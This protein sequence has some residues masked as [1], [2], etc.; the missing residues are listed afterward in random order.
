MTK[1][2]LVGVWREV[3][4]ELVGPDGSVKRDIPRASQ[5][6]YTA[7][8][9]MSVVNA[10][11]GRAAVTEADSRMDLNAAG[12]EARAQAALGVVAYAG[13]FEVEGD[14][15]LHR[16]FTSLNPNRVGET[17]QR[18]ATLNGDDLTLAAPP[19]ARGATFRIHW[20]RA[21]KMPD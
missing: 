10:P 17:Q 16:I 19:D 14:V 12:A 8:G 20:R 1:D 18:R 15:V 5:I 2:D 21:A 6:V 3:G 7:D 4:R 13:R 9:Y 11:R